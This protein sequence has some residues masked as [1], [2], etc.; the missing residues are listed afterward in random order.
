MPHIEDEGIVLKGQLS[1][2]SFF[3]GVFFIFTL[4]SK[5]IVIIVIIIVVIVIKVVVVIIVIIISSVGER[6]GDIIR[7]ARWS[8]SPWVCTSGYVIA[9]CRSCSTIRGGICCSTIGE[10]SSVSLRS[11]CRCI[12]TRVCS[13][14][15]I[16]VWSGNSFFCCCNAARRRRICCWFR[17]A[18]SGTWQRGGCVRTVRLRI[19]SYN[20]KESLRW[21]LK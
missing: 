9:S 10:R 7:G 19:L 15:N 6:S 18:C 5:A 16:I 1:A 4:C 8:R 2:N 3:N 11:P 12:S 17:L 20:E 21:L 13:S 14:G